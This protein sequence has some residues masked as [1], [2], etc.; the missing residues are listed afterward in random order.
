MRVCGPGAASVGRLWRAW[1]LAAVV[2]V[3]ATARG[4]AQDGLGGR[5]GG[6]G[7]IP[8]G[9][10]TPE[11]T[12]EVQLRVVKVGPG[13]AARLGEW[14]G[15]LVEVVDQRGPREVVLSVQGVDP[16]GD[17]PRYERVL[18]TNPGQRQ[19]AWLY[20]DL[21]PGAAGASLSVT[22][23]R[24][25]EDETGVAAS[26]YRLGRLLASRP[27]DL[28]RTV[29]ASTGLVGQI[30][31]ADVGLGA[32]G[33][34]ES[35]RGFAPLVHELTD[36]A[37]GMTIDD[38]PDRWQG[39][40]A[41]EAIVWTGTLNRESPLLL[42]V[43]RARAVE[44]WVRR[45]GHLVVVLP[46]AGQDWFAQV[47]NPLASILPRVLP[48]ERSEAQAW[49]SLRPLV[50]SQSEAAL[51]KTGVLQRMRPAPG[52]GPTDAMAILAGPAGADAAGSGLASG[53]EAAADAGAVVVRRLVG[54]GA[55]T[56]VGVDLVGLARS[57]PGLPEVGAFWHRVLG[58]RGQYLTLE[59][60]RRIDNDP[61]HP[62]RPA[63]SQLADR[64]VVSFDADLAEAVNQ[65]R[66]AEA[67]VLLGFVVF[68]AYWVVAGPLGF[69]LLKRNDGR[70]HAWAA[71][72][73]TTGAFTAIAWLGAGVIR[74]KSVR[75][76]YVQVVR[77]VHGQGTATAAGWASV[78]VP[79]YGEA[80]LS[81]ADAGA[82]GAGDGSVGG[83]GTGPSEAAGAAGAA[84]GLAATLDAW[85]GRAG[86]SSGRFPD[87][88]EY[89]V[90][91][92]SPA[93][94]RP[95]VRATVKQVRYSVV[96]PAGEGLGRAMPRPV[97]QPGDLE[98][99]VLTLTEEFE[100]RGELAHD[101]PAGLEDAVVVVV[102]RQVSLRSTG[103]LRDR[104]VSDVWV[105]PVESLVGTWEAGERLDLAKL[106]YRE[107]LGDRASDRADRYL[108]A[109]LSR[110]RPVAPGTLSDGGS[111]GE[112]LF[113]LSLFQQLSP[114]D[115]R[116]AGVLNR[117]SRL[118]RRGEGRWLDLSRWF[119]QPCVIV[120]GLMRQEQEREALPLR[121]DGE[122]F[123][124]S[125]LTLVQWVYPLPA[126]PPRYADDE[127][128]AILGAGAA[129]DG[130]AG[131]GA[132]AEDGPEGGAADGDGGAGG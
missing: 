6:G 46:V 90:D 18:T 120:L 8:G 103:G 88:R 119:T 130:G 118:A 115:P 71:F 110:G 85:E 87:N 132:A 61:Q 82:E 57:S 41:F 89:A 26:G 129:A 13:S 39:L 95:P 74:P 14:T 47:S 56:F 92:R 73:G 45:G 109:L 81:V 11:D 114:P 50:T 127:V 86:A 5:G 30:G 117:A 24:A 65:S 64:T 51:R 125:G 20:L 43:E 91:A 69:S 1:A 58:R 131:T 2:C 80:T 72:L 54:D 22:V 34:N 75:G 62:L 107:R 79:W 9:V 116:D 113:G 19:T 97:G 123:A 124:S 33:V 17:T 122:A 78:L 96:R 16:D 77:Q 101:L 48:P 4:V 35:G 112:R 42:S 93:S 32:Y 55:V 10:P 70:R 53:S 111:L 52:A 21:P 38:L 94:L 31:T 126:T 83:A 98:A 49:E 7:V 3:G 27:L 68:A 25:V 99:P 12:G 15:V 63:V 100:V 121:V 23:H 104:L 36:V 84:D 29:E 37:R 108:E 105:Y 60:L 106:T 59:D 128:R 44:A 66:A 67:G 76:E 102:G 28:G 40:A